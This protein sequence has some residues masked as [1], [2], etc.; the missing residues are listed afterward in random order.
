MYHDHDGPIHHLPSPIATVGGFIIVDDY[1]DWRS[2]M[3]AVD[4]FRSKRGI[5]QPL[6]LIPHMPGNKHTNKHP[7]TLFTPCSTVQAS[8]TLLY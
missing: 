1:S 8:Y 7:K 6:V 4:E 5:T 3:T 2:C